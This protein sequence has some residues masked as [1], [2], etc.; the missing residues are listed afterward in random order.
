MTRVVAQ[1]PSSQQAGETHLAMRPESQTGTPRPAGT[2]SF[3]SE[4]AI[5]PGD[6]VPAGDALSLPDE[7]AMDTHVPPV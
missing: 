2:S 7:V 6:F 3:D 5:P 1:P 4:I